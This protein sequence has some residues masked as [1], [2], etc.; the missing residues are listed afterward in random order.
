MNIIFIIKAKI[1]MLIEWSYKSPQIVL[2]IKPK[3]D[4]H[5][6]ARSLTSYKHVSFGVRSCMLTHIT[7]QV[8]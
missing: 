5:F 6:W 3:M 7:T 2:S 4:R 8:Y 1:L